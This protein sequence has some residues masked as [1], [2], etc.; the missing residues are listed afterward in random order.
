M[1]GRTLALMS[2]F[3]L[4][5]S[6][7]NWKIT[8]KWS[9]KCFKIIL[10]ISRSNYLQFS[11]NLPVKCTILQFL[12]SFLFINKYLQLNNLKT[13]IAMNAKTS[14][15]VICVETI[16]YLLLYN[17]YDCTFNVCATI[18]T[19]YC[20]SC[21][22]SIQRNTC[23]K[24]FRYYLWSKMLLCTLHNK[25][26]SSDEKVLLSDKKNHFYLKM[27]WFFFFFFLDLF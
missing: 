18:I 12:L 25:N 6:H 24:R 22:E 5:Y 10:K 14:V 2:R 19:I 16:I 20:E 4:R 15:F 26:M 8:D 21:K 17:L 23:K 9:L 3:D 7:A 1:N 27:N 11:T 13:R